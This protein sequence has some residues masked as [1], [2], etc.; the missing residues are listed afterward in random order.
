[1]LRND[2]L[3]TKLFVNNEYLDKYIELI[4][5]N[6]GA[7]RVKFKTTAHHVVPKY[8]F[9]YQNLPVDN[10]ETNIVHIS[11]SDHV[12]AHF[13]LANC[14]KQDIHKWF[15]YTAMNHISGNVFAEFEGIEDIL[16]DEFLSELQQLKETSLKV[17]SE[18]G[19]LLIPYVRTEATLKKLSDKLTGYIHIHKGDIRKMIP[20]QEFSVYES[21]GWKLGRG[22]TSM[23][24]EGKQRFREKRMGHE[25]TENT[26]QK[27]KAARAKQSKEKGEPALGHTMSQKSKDQMREKLKNKVSINDGVK[28]LHVDKQDLQYYLDKGFFKGRLSRAWI[29]RAQESKSVLLID[30][31]RY[32]EQGW[33]RGRGSIKKG[34]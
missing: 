24:E 19:K 26:K 28:E 30:V 11:Y 9:D 3:K 33:E 12:L 15:N 20:P 34:K 23:S 7:V 10:T 8:C 5:R 17:A 2:L 32:I 18:Q 21:D 1:M 16:T 31:D 6:K 29:H 22:I 4:E 27:I 25:V 13:F 14:S